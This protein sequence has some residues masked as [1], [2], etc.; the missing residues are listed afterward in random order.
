LNSKDKHNSHTFSDEFYDF[1]HNLEDF[2]QDL[3]ESIIEM[4]D[5]FKEDLSDLREEIKGTFSSCCE[6]DQG[7]RDDHSEVYIK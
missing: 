4:V 3:K 2:I 6:F 1:F 7:G 5:N